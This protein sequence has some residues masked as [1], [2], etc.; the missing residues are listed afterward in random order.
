MIS[1]R[2]QKINQYRIDMSKRENKINSSIDDLKKQI[3]AII[4]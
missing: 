2:T 1:D 3:N 4:E